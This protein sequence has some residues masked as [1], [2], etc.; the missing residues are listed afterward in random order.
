[1]L[2]SSHTQ[3]QRKKGA[4]NHEFW[5]RHCHHAEFVRFLGT[6]PAQGPNI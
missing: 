3:E 1:M 2:L 5:L 4:D 6:N